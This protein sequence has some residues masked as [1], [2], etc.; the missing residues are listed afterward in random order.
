MNTNNSNLLKIFSNYLG[1]I[2]N[3]LSVFLFVPMY[4]HYLGIES[5]AVIAFYSLILG[6]IGFADAGMSSAT[7]REF[8]LVKPTSYKEFILS[9]IER[10][11]WLVVLIISTII[12]IF[13]G[14][15]AKNW[16]Q[17]DSI[18]LGD[19][20]NY[21]ILIGIGTSLQLLS[22][23]YFGSMFGLG[24]QVQA[25]FLQIIW[26]TSRTLLVVLLFI[27]Y[28]KSLYVFFLWQIACN[29]IYIL[30]LRTATKR[31]LKRDIT[32]LDS[33]ERKFP[34][35]IIKYISG[36]VIVALISAINSQADKLVV[37]YFFDLKTFGYY[38]LTSILSQ[39][40]V[41]IA[42]PMASFAFPLLSKL[43]SLDDKNSFNVTF[44]K[45]SYLL[46]FL[47]IPIGVGIYFYPLEILLF[48]TNNGIEKNTYSDIILL[49][50]TLTI[51]S[52]FL[53][54]QVPLFYSLLAY[55]KTKYTVYQ[56]IFQISLGVPLLLSI[57]KYH[58]L[59]YIG[60][61]WLIINVL[62]FL[63]LMHVCFTRYIN[64]N[65]SKFIIESI[66]Y[67]TFISIFLTAC[68][69]YLYKKYHLP[70]LIPLIFTGILIYII[71]LVLHNIQ[72]NRSPL[73][74]K[75]LYNFPRD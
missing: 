8:A 66:A 15:I 2:W 13:S 9:K 59:K 32:Y 24:K 44:E 1:K 11:Y 36:M 50:K 23:L 22:S 51:G 53:A 17:N 7:I 64:I 21:V 18:P 41:I 20:R 14:F 40:P 48:W 75:N 26:I 27:L 63:Y 34:K 74:L 29:I 73:S 10:F 52:V 19:L 58:G 16:L 47:V 54:F 70:F 46:Y 38:T 5:Y 65:I 57:A 39:I 3:M 56:G 69:H 68:G 12:A 33:F 35:R 43:S 67:T 45:F 6:V 49:I 72:N 30:L 28:K 60:I 42:L 61:P 55:S 25:N 37:S 31:I 71:N 62:A 4:I